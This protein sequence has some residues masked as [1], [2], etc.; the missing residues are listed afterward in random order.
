VSALTVDGGLL[1]YGIAEDE[2]G[3]PTVPTPID[4]AGARETHIGEIF[5]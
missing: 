2:H 3:R 4:L 5:G 1:I